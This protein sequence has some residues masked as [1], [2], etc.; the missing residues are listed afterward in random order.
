M[1]GKILRFSSAC[2]PCLTLTDGAGLIV[3]ETA[4]FWITELPGKERKRVSKSKGHTEPCSCCRDHE[5]TQYPNG[6]MD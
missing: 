5:R 3:G 2:G 1:I 4:K 6:Y